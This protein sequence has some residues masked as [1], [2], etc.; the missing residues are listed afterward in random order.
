MRTDVLIAN[1][2]SSQRAVGQSDYIIRASNGAWYKVIIDSAN[3]DI[4]YVKSTDRGLTWSAPV[5]IK[6][7]TNVCG[8][9]VWYDG[10]TPGD[11]G[12]KIH[13]AYYEDTTDDVFYRY[14]DTASDTLG[15]E[16]TVFAGASATYVNAS[17]CISITKARGGYIF[18]AFDID[19]GTE[20]GFYRS[21]DGGGTFGARTDVNEATSDYYLLFPG[22]YAD[23]N[24]I[25]CIYWDRSAN[26]ISLKVHDDSA[27]SWA[28]TS[29]AASMVDLASTTAAP[30]F[31]GLVRD[32]DG[33]LILVA[34]SD[35]DLLNSDLRCWD[36][37]GSGSITEKTNVVQ[38]STDDQAVCGIAM[39]TDN[40]Y[41]YVFY[42][43]KS[44]GSNTAYTSMSVNYKFS[45]DGGTTWSSEITLSAINRGFCTLYSNLLF[46]GGEFVVAY[47]ATGAALSLFSSAIIP[48]KI[49]QYQIGI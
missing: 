27:N 30:Q 35:A 45:T 19:G 36:I 49:P 18:V 5:G 4:Y 9:A 23:A 29:I 20:L 28:E 34:W 11:S 25:D 16:I 37:N 8:V 24:D 44:D 10:W 22:N 3:I 46:S 12:T 40:D 33:H 47:G 21:T 14:L 48:N 6:T 7:G 15:S 1:I 42:L 41:L 39:D 2:A 32:T 43:G 17:A 13:V 38:N 31:A 26:E